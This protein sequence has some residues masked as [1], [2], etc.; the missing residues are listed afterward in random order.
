MMPAK[1]VFLGSLRRWYFSCQCSNS[2]RKAVVWSTLAST[3]SREMYFL[4]GKK[5]AR[6]QTVHRFEFRCRHMEGAVGAECEEGIVAGPEMRIGLSVARVEFLIEFIEL[7]AAIGKPLQRRPPQLLVP[8][9]RPI[10]FRDQ[11]IVQRAV[12]F[13]VDQVQR[14]RFDGG[15][16]LDVEQCLVKRYAKLAV[17][18]E[19]GGLLL[20]GQKGHRRTL[21]DGAGLLL[22]MPDRFPECRLAALGI[23]S[24]LPDNL[25]NPV[26]QFQ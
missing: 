24:R 7:G 12:L 8:A 11:I 9:R 23:K 21:V 4:S 16:N 14:P 22:V 20:G 6:G 13:R 18:I 10:G 25:R 5:V 17:L 15:G 26:L 3:S 19:H 1:K 2:S